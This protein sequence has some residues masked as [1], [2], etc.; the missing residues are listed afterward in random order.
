[1]NIYG[2][3]LFDRG[4]D[5]T[6]P[7]LLNTGTTRDPF[8]EVVGH[9]DNG[10]PIPT[11]E[12]YAEKIF[13]SISRA[14]RAGVTYNYKPEVSHLKSVNDEVYR[15]YMAILGY[16]ESSRPIIKP[17]ELFSI[18]L[19]EAEGINWLKKV[20][21]Y[22][23]INAMSCHVTMDDPEDAYY[24]QEAKRFPLVD[25]GDFFNVRY[26]LFWDQPDDKMW[27]ACFIPCV[28]DKGLM[29]EFEE[30][31]LALLPDIVIEPVLEEEILLQA[32]SSSALEVGSGKT[33]PNWYCKQKDNYFTSKPL[34]AK[35]NYIQKCPGDTRFP[36]TM[37]VPCSNTIK[38]IEKQVAAIASEMPWSAYVKDTDEYFKRFNKF[39]SQSEWF[40]C[41]DTKKDGL[42][43]NRALVQAVLRCIKKKWPALPA[44][45]YFGIF[46]GFSLEVEG[47][48]LYPPRGVGLGMS[49][50]IT[51]IIQCTV[52]RMCLNEVYK[53]YQVGSLDCLAYH[54]DIAFGSDCEDTME[55]FKDIDNMICEKLAIPVNHRKGFYGLNFVLCENY[56]DPIFGEKESYQR[57]ALKQ[58]HASENVTHAKF[59][60]LSVFRYVNPEL[61]KQ[62]IGELIS[63]F[64]NEFYAGEGSAPTLLG[65]WV[66][67]SYQKVDITLYNMDRLPSK[68]EFAA[69]MVSLVPV[70]RF[71]G[72]RPFGNAPYKPPVKRIFPQLENFGSTSVFLTD[73]TESQVGQSMTRL[74]KIG[75]TSWYWRYQRV[76]R[77][78]KFKHLL[79]GSWMDQ[80]TWYR[81]LRKTHPSTD[82]MPPKEL[83]TETPVEVYPQV[84]SLF[85]P[86]N[87]KMSY[88]AAMNPG[89]L[90]EKI[91]PWPVPPEV[92]TVSTLS[93]T[94]F[95]RS[96]V[97]FES[98]LFNRHTADL[99]EMEIAIPTLRAINSDE[100]FSPMS[101]VSFILAMEHREYLPRVEPRESIA[102]IPD[103]IF[104]LVN[105]P[106]HEKLFV[107]LAGRLGVKRT[108]EIQLTYFEHEVDRFLQARRAKKLKEVKRLVEQYEL[109]HPEEHGTDSSNESFSEVSDFHFT[110]ADLNDCDF[111]TW[112]TGARNY[113]NWRNFFFNSMDEKISSIE[114]IE[115][116]FMNQEIDRSQLLRYA[117]TD[118]V[119]IHL[120]KESGGIFDENMVPILD[121]AMAVGSDKGSAV[122]DMFA[123]GSGDESSEG[124]LMIGF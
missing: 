22:A 13:V 10:H 41:R 75:L 8:T 123:A 3:E 55:N 93:L 49:S 84:N 122:G 91:I 48:T 1:M 95:E 81:A 68:E 98:H 52:F 28:Y 73:M 86:A 42:T 111:F 4:L 102:K 63:H 97:K 106:N 112:R 38:L 61:W 45:K 90:S 117:F 120:Y 85:S 103:Q 113:N 94:A 18:I 11:G 43:K 88:L 77:H 66:P 69:S 96:K 99:R 101:V 9:S 24:I 54:D 65:G 110:D 6:V 2:K 121:R 19:K 83:I 79:D 114:I 82:I 7:P 58:L 71:P 46:D 80:R 67:Y 39:R 50:A 56:S 23:M 21:S 87:P 78:K 15:F 26:W 34:H 47:K 30:E 35:G 104:Y 31:C 60:W 57:I 74:M 29:K 17:D 36:I 37:S 14:W 32:T 62:Y 40:Y 16:Y 44:C 72:R 64:G 105:D 25:L 115:S 89:K 59:Q 12:G 76:E 100:W 108:K 92:A 109:D 20:R 70:K 124:G 118:A 27:E 119:E 107:Y 51:T 53:E 5:L 116:G 33:K